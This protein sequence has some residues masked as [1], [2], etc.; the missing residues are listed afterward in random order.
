MERT[1]DTGNPNNG[2]DDDDRTPPLGLGTTAGGGDDDGYDS[3]SSSGSLAAD[4]Q[5]TVT[6]AYT[7]QR[8]RLRRSRNG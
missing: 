2:E 5:F 3:I 4:R 7:N 8:R 1:S 6:E